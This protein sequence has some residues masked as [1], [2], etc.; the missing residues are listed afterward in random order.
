MRGGDFTQRTCPLE[1]KGK[2]KKKNTVKNVQSCADRNNLRSM[3]VR[4]TR[5]S[6]ADSPV[7]PL[8]P[9]SSA[10]PGHSKTL[11]SFLDAFYARPEEKCPCTCW[12]R[13][14]PVSAASGSRSRGADKVAQLAAARWRSPARL[15]ALHAFSPLLN[16]RQLSPKWQRDKPRLGSKSTSR[17]YCSK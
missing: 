17:W 1:K 10:A 7:P 6:P 11:G 2:K 13:R 5:V 14:E 8:P 4:Q 16:L 9:R 3:S 15:A 12:W